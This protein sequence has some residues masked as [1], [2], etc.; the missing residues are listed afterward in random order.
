[1]AAGLEISSVELAQCYLAA[2]A[3]GSTD[4]NDNHVH[5]SHMMFLC[6]Y[7]ECGRGLEILSVELAQCYVPGCWC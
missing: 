2:A 7:L 5:N 4:N 3:G 6:R 1:M